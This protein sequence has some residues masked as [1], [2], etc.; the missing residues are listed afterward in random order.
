MLYIINFADAKYEKIRKLNSFTARYI[1]KADRII[2]YRF[3]DIDS[4][5]F[6]ENSEIFKIKRGA[7]LWIWKPYFILKT[8]NKMN[9]GDFLFYC[10]SGSFFIK[11][12][13]SLVEKLESSKQS[14]MGFELPLLDRQFTKRET[15]DALSYNR[16]DNNQILASY[17]LFK[18]NKESLGFV[19]EWLECCKNIIA[20]SPQK[21]TNIKEFDDFVAHREDQSIFSILYNKSNLKPFKDPSQFGE[22]PREYMWVS[23]FS[24]WSKKWD[25]IGLSDS[26]QQTQQ[27]KLLI[28]CRNKNPFI[29]LLKEVIKTIYF[30]LNLYPNSQKNE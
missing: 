14:I 8:L 11:K 19:N 23:S 29:Y 2:E 30:K 18:K 22:R 5:F 10:D 28:H 20:L 7:G 1:A 15:Y 12:L 25:Y 4:D 13:D 24:S 26:V 21:F 17:I 6:N 3:E 16:Y 9:D 27:K